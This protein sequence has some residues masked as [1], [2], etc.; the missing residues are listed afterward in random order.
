MV[1]WVHSSPNGISTSLCFSLSVCVSARLSAV[2][3]ATVSAVAAA[4]AA[5]DVDRAYAAFAL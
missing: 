5:A 1:P 3:T 4:A 2:T